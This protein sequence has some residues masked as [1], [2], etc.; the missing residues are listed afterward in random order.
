MIYFSVL[1]RCTSTYFNV[2]LYHAWVQDYIDAAPTQMRPLLT[3]ITGT[4]MFAVL[5]QTRAEELSYPLVFFERSTSLARL[6]N[7]GLAASKEAQGA[8]FSRRVSRST[9]SPSFFVRSH[10][11]DKATLQSIEDKFAY[12]GGEIILE[13]DLLYVDQHN[14]CDDFIDDRSLNRRE[15]EQETN[16]LSLRDKKRGPLLVPGPELPDNY[17]SETD[18]TRQS[19]GNPLEKLRRFDYRS[20]WPELDAEVLSEAEAVQRRRVAHLRDALADAAVA[21]SL[22]LFP[23]SL[24]LTR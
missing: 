8:S 18:C 15:L 24:L 13:R 12:A 17:S 4:Q 7:V 19:E 11:A 23:P 22:M 2:L 1:L 5:L 21:V 16:E 6:L 10:S 3:S 20:G 9:D 14:Y